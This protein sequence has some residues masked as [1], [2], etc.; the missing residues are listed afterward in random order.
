MNITTKEEL[1]AYTKRRMGGQAHNI[2]LTPEQWED[3]L[4]MAYRQWRE[5]SSQGNIESVYVAEFA[6]GTKDKFKLDDSILA[7]KAIFEFQDGTTGSGIDTMFVGSNLSVPVSMATLFNSASVTSSAINLFQVRQS[8][9]SA[10]RMLSGEKVHYDYNT[11]TKNLAILD[12]NEHKSLTIF[13]TKAEPLEECL[14]DENLQLL[15]QAFALEDWASLLG[16]KYDQS[17]AQIMGNG[18][19]L[20][21]TRMEEKALALREEYQRRLEDFELDTLLPLIIT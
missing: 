7:V 1:I 13:V 8:I 21:I 12:G 6:D 17:N 2:E 19:G 20:N 14:M 10:K 15:V 3:I 18:L 11:N 9:D 5:Q 16:L 4:T